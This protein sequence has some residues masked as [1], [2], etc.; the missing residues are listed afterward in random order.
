MCEKYF[1]GNFSSYITFLI[2]SDKYNVSRAT[3]SYDDTDQKIEDATVF[4]PD[5]ENKEFLSA[6]DSILNGD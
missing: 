4:K 6:I 5:K 1:G 3:V 2:C